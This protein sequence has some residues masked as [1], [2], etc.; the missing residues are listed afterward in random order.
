[1]AV[2]SER[3]KSVQISLRLTAPG[4]AALPWEALYDSE[5]QTTCAARS[6]WCG[7]CRRRTPPP[8]LE[9]APPL[10]VLAMISSPRGLPALDVE[11]SASACRRR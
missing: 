3:G 7:T 2:A 8:A 1:M 10:R 11:A 6:R 9:V 5:T 4:L